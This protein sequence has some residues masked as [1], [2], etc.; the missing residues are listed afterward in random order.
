MEDHPNADSLY[1]I[2]LHGDTNYQTVSDLKNSF[3]KSDLL[4]KQVL[5]IT[6]LEKATI[7]GIDSECLI[8]SVSDGN[9]RELISGSGSDGDPAMLGD[10]LYNG[11]HVLSFKELQRVELQISGHH[12]FVRLGEKLLPLMLN[13]IYINVMP[14]NMERVL[15]K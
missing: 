6:N 14:E 9:S 3:A 5:I 8:M 4:G 7:R 12:T 1:V 2:K 10:Y 15:I 11:D 13:K